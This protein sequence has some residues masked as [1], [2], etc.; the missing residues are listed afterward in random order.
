MN[1]DKE[2]PTAVDYVEWLLKHMLRTSRT[3]L[4]IDTRCRLPGAGEEGKENAPP[5]LPAAGNVLNRLKVLSGLNPAHY[6]RM[7]EGSFE[8][9]SIGHVLVVNTRFLDEGNV[10][11]CSLR[12]RIRA[13]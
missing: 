11:T 2:E 4:T 12:L 8:R 5:C 1:H 9:P 13:K 10:S 6:G 7:T 3:E